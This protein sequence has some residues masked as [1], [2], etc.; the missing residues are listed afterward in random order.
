MKEAIKKSETLIEALP[1][2]KKFFEKTIVIKYGGAAVDEKGI[3]SAILEDIMFM[4]YAGMRLVVVHGGGPYISKMMKKSGIEPKFIGG[5]RYTDEATLKI[6][7]HALAAINGRIVSTLKGMGARVFATSGRENNL[8]RAKKMDCGIDLGYVGEVTSVDT[9]V[10]KRL[11]KDNIIPVIYPIGLGR[12]RHMYNVNADDVASEI[13]VALK[14]EKFI[15]LTNVKGVLKDRKDPGS[16]CH[17]LKA[18]EAERLIKRKII[19]GGMIP[20]AR[21]CINA[22]KGGVKKAHILDAGI[23]HAL[24]L[25]MFTDKGIGT[26]IV[27]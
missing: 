14:A 16:L 11:I 25:E 12:D 19:D 4:N 3:D 9:T 18:V 8:I 27:R 21:S 13:A 10:I 17:T 2:I 22:I 6:I 7:D 23:P 20:K 24:L 1:Y 5:R 26:E 15:L